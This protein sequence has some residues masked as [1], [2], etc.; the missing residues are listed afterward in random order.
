MGRKPGAAR[1]LLYLLARGISVPFVVAPK[2]EGYENNLY[3]TAMAHRIR[4]ISD[5]ELY[6]LIQ[7]NHKDV[8]DI[9][10]VISYLF[11]NRIKKPLLALARLGCINF[12]PAPLPDYKGRAGYNTAI[13]D[14]RPW[15]GVSAHYI[16]S[17]DFDNGPIIKT[18]TFP[19]DPASETAL[20][21]EAR[22]Q[23]KLYELFEEVM[24]L[25]IKGGPITTIP[26][27][28]GMHLTGRQL[29][30]LKL[31]D[32]EKD[33]PQVIERKIRAFF[34]PPYSGAKIRAGGKEYTLIN[35]KIL[36]LLAELQ[37]K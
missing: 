35:D 1:A 28:N 12:H 23:S 30:E 33:S 5:K 25:F 15:F 4:T 9:D 21:L 16:D 13:L 31:V 29:E 2:D 24:A 26:N 34:F 17:E 27:Q 36:K 37:N 18:L 8:Q 7:R 3:K 14:Q 6:G 22:A 19:I 10:L 32:L 11:W 20:S